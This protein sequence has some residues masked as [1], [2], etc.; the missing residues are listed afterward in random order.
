MDGMSAEGRSMRSYDVVSFGIAAVDDLVELAEFP[1][2]DTK[3][4]IT[5]IERQPGGQGSTALVAAARQGMKCAYAG[6]LGR[7]EL[8]D[9]TRR[10]FEREHID[11]VS[12]NR[13][14]EAKPFYS[15]IL[16]DR[17]NGERTILYSGAGVRGIGREDVSEDL[18][19]DSRVLL[20][21]QLGTEGTLHA[22]RLARKTG[23]QVIADFERVDD[24]LRE[25]MGLTGHLILPLRLARELTGCDGAEEAVRAL[26][27]TDRAC[28]AATDG[29]RGCWFMVGDGKVVHQAAYKVDVVDTTGCGDAFH[30]AYAAALVKGKTAA[31]AMRYAAAAAALC[32]TQYGGQG[33]IPDGAAVERFLAERSQ[34]PFCAR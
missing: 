32:A 1:R 23:T 28:T 19:A 12:S 25:A 6:L 5:R 10:V 22:C 11:L 15:I 3:T 4:P 27:R 30:G 18:I 2:P 20:V 14:P 21:D 24:N 7:N 16:V 33:G 31:E 13:Y 8:S 9:F 26:G 34:G 29:S 17:S